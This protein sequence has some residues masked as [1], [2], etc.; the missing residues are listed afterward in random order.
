MVTKVKDMMVTDVVT[1]DGTDT[2]LEALELMLTRKV[3]SAVV[4][5]KHEH[6]A[7]AIVTFTDIA[8]RVLAE[9]EQIEMLNVFDVM[10]RPAYS[11]EAQWDIRYAAR[12]MTNLGISRV[13]VTDEGKLVGI[14]SLSDLVRS[15]SG[16]GKEK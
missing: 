15:L 12:M 14:V 13:L 3:K 11:A 9:D 7:Y 16:L 2:L 4:P 6:D 1:I 5:P 10:S 8:R